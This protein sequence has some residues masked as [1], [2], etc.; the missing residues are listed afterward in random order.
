[1]THQIWSSRHHVTLP[2]Y[3]TDDTHYEMADMR[4]NRNQSFTICQRL[5]LLRK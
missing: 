4:T 5:Q 1:M 2:V 3:L